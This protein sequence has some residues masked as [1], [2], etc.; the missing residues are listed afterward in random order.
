MASGRPRQVC[1]RTWYACSKFRVPQRNRHAHR[2]HLHLTRNCW[3]KASVANLIEGSC[4]VTHNQDSSSA[5]GCVR[6]RVHAWKFV[7]AYAHGRKHAHKHILTCTRT[8]V[9][10][11]AHLNT[12]ALSHTHTSHKFALSFSHTHVKT[13]Q[14]AHMRVHAYTHAHIT[15][16]K[17]QLVRLH[18]QTL[19][20][21]SSL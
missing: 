18:I 11:Q 6:L 1:E 5:V 2:C 14:G 10:V 7:H 8:W 20:Q 3:G 21:L 16:A 12:Y 13:Y 17:M 4:I 15:H 19:V 9:H